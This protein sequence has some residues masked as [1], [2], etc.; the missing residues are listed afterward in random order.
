L[1]RE[2]SRTVAP[3]LAAALVALLAA[4]AAWAGTKTWAGTF[5]STG[6]NTAGNWSPS[7]VPGPGDDVVVSGASNMNINATVDVLSFSV[8]SG[9]TNTISG[10]QS[11]RIRGNLNLASNAGTFTATSGTMQ[12]DGAFNRTGTMTFN[13][14]GG[15]ILL[16]ASSNQAHAFNGA[17]LANVKIKDNDGLVGWWA[18]DDNT[19]TSGVDGSGY[20]Q[21]G[22]FVGSPSWTTSVPSVSF[23]DA[24]ALSFNGTN[25]QFS[26]PD[27]SR[28]ELTGDITIAFWA[29]RANDTT[30]WTRMVGKGNATQRNYGVWTGPSNGYTVLFQQYNASGGSVL[31]L[32]GSTVLAKNTWYHIACTVSGTAASLYVNGVLE[33]TGT[34][35]GTPGTSTDALLLGYGSPHTYFNGRLDDVRI[36][37]RALSASDV[38][39]LGGGRIPAY[40]SVVHT[41]SNAFVATGDLTLLSG[42]LSNGTSNIT[43]GGSWKNQGGIFTAGTGT[44][45]LN[46]TAST[47]VLQTGQYHFNNLT[48]SNSGTW[49]MGDRLWIDNTLTMTNGTLNQSSSNYSVR[50]G[51]INKSG[52]TLTGGGSLVLTSASASTVTMN[53]SGIANF[54]VD[55]PTDASLLGYWRLDGDQGTTAVDSGPNAFNGTYT[56]GVAPTTSVSSTVAIDNPGAAS[57][58]GSNGYIT[59]PNS[60]SL[61]LTGDFTISLWVYRAGATSDWVR[62][63]GKGDSTNRNYGVWY[64]PGISYQVLFQQYDS[65]GGVVMQAQS[66]TAIPVGTW[67]HVAV[68]QTGT[69]GRIYINGVLDGTATRSGTPATSTDPLTFGYAGFHGYHYGSMDEVRMYTRALSASE[70]AK[71]A[72]GRP[73]GV[74]GPTFTLAQALSVTGDVGIDNGGLDVT[75]AGCAGASCSI[76]AGGSFL[77]SGVFTAR[78]GT[79]TL[80][81]SGTANSIRTNGYQFNNLTVSGTGTWTL[82]D[83]P[84]VAATY[85]QSAG[86]VNLSASNYN[87]TAATANKSGGTLTGGGSLILSASTSQNVQIN[88]AAVAAVQLGTQSTTGLVGYW[89]LDEASGTSIADSSGSGNTGTLQNGYS[90][91]TSSLPSMQFTDTAAISLNGSANTYATLGTANLPANNAAQTISVWFKDA[92]PDTGNHNMV[93]LSNL[94]NSGVQVG[95][96]GSNLLAWQWGGNP[97][98][99]T[100]APTDGLWHHVAYTYDLTWH[101][102][103]L[104]GVLSDSKMVTPQTGTVSGAFIGTYSTAGGELYNGKLDDVRVYNRAL[105]ATEVANLAG[106]RYY[107]TLNGAAYTMNGALSTTG[108]LLIYAGSLDATAAGCA[109]ASCAITVGGSFTNNGTFTAR[110]GTVTLNGSSTGKSITSNLSHLYNLTISGTGGWSLLDRLWV[111]STYT[112]SAAGSLAAGTY[113][114]WVGNASQTAGTLTG[115]GTLALHSRANATTNLSGSTMTNVR[116][117]STGET[118]LVGYWKFDEGT[119]TTVTD[120]SGNGN[121]GTLVSTTA[122]TATIPSTVSFDNYNA[123]SLNGSSD[124]V[125][126]GTTNL[127]NNNSAQTVSAWVKFASAAGNQNIVALSNNS[128]AGVQVGLGGGNVRVWKWGGTDLVASAAPSTTTVWHHIAWTFDGTNN[129]LYVDGA[130]TNTSMV[131]IPTNTVTTALIGTYNTGT[132][133]E[134]FGGLVDDVRIYK[135]ALTATQ[136]AA[137]AAGRYTAVGGGATFTLGTALN[138]PGTLAVDNGTLATAGFA[139][140]AASSDSSKTTLVN[141]GTLSLGASTLTANAGV[142]VQ[143]GSS[144]TQTSTS[145]VLLGA[146]KST[147]YYDTAGVIEGFPTAAFNWTNFSYWN[148]YV[149]FRTFSGTTD[150]LLA[151]SQDGGAE[152]FWDLPG[153]QG[154]IIGAPRW[155]MESGVHYVYLAT[156]LGYIYKIQDTGSAFS[157][158]AG[159]PYRNG[160]SATATAPLITDSNNM[161]WPGNDGTGARK[162]FSLT[163]GKTLNNTQA[164]GADVVAVPTL[165]S[166]SGTSYLFL[167]TSSTVYRMARDA[168][169]ETTGTPG[170]TTSVGG[171][172]TAYNNTLYLS[173]DNGKVWALNNSSLASTWSYQDTDATRHPGGCT[174]A[175]QCTVKNLWYDWP[176][177]QVI[178]GDQDGHVYSVNNG[179]LSAG[180]PWRPGTSADQFLTAPIV[181]SSAGVVVMG[182]ANGNVYFIDR[183]TGTGPALIRTVVLPGAPSTIAYNNSANG[184]TGAVMI[185]T[186]DGKLFYLAPE[187]DPT[188]AVR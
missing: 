3:S 13:G 2:V 121:T 9:Y 87:L 7:G 14:N 73:L 155:N 25:A 35:S 140:N 168:S 31:D 162:I 38:S 187:S 92:T 165:A 71:L 105:S 120:W 1:R 116:F 117:E 108:D 37:N 40:S 5:L 118:N 163:L 143:A 75:A 43:V 109:G 93:A 74:S 33:A 100:T 144:L 178:Y 132:P 98:A 126:L 160:T 8:N 86:T 159:W 188:P 68:T 164:L 62:M 177:N 125:T 181:M 64:G 89:K 134:Y 78:T 49:T 135:V 47:N 152:Y 24:A 11:I 119:G 83:A 97:L 94:T 46:G 106:G 136:V 42:T 28:L 130:Q 10:N 63:V 32:Q 129:R 101:R 4:P 17:S 19:G 29:Y 180:Y 153:S 167:A 34:R 84:T 104:D 85:T 48:I 147:S 22:S 26:V 123:L 65:S 12:I 27:N 128:N 139:V 59:V 88:S 112:M 145:K 173:E 166:V 156:T 151:R 170:I 23:S 169:A 18:L 103:Y 122:R 61:Q 56:G 53:S 185:G 133:G 150:R 179:V 127:P 82:A 90:W 138:V 158:V 115:T 172:I 58:G 176:S 107:D 6:W 44:V 81:G 174:A 91:L 183:S 124:Y 50:A 30:D 113:N 21:T 157:T 57:F 69:T 16:D 96:R 175:S 70:I 99:S 15:T 186:A 161:Y 36:Y 66:T 52:G 95:L 141:S 154:N 80:N 148:T 114:V 182:A 111:D 131:T 149:V 54:R 20:G 79:V 45:T 60:S 77:N 76:T 102:I 55:S 72:A 146:G 171:H 39:T 184:G 142:I 67:T 137:L 51:A 41:L 110:T